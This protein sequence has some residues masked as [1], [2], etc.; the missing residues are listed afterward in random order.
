VNNLDPVIALGN[1]A[2]IN[3]PDISQASSDQ[4]AGQ[5]RRV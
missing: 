3:D 2:Q 4:Q 1:H 5:A